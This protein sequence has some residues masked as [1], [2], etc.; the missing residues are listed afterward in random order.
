[1][2]QIA[3]GTLS[4]ASVTISSLSTYDN[5]FLAL[6]GYTNSTANGYPSVKINN[7]STSN[8]AHYNVYFDASSFQPYDA[9]LS[10]IHLTTDP[11]ERTSNAQLSA[12]TLTNCKTA[13]FTNWDSNCRVYTGANKAH[14]IKGVYTV[15]EAVSSLVIF[16]SGGNW[17]GGTY[18]LWGA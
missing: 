17:A 18:T 6:T 9:T 2:A 15:S 13:G 8:Y 14:F 12:L 10:A 3:T 1:M 5:L 16:N 11:A 4:G 7:V